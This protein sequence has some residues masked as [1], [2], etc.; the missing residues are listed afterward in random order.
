MSKKHWDPVAAYKYTIG[1]CSSFAF[2]STSDPAAT[3]SS[4][5]V[6]YTWSNSVGTTYEYGFLAYSVFSSSLSSFTASF[7]ALRKLAASVAYRPRVPTVA[8]QHA[9][10]ASSFLASSFTTSSTASSFNARNIA[11]LGANCLNPTLIFSAFVIIIDDDAA[12][13]FFGP[14]T[15]FSIADSINR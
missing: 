9:F 10:L 14:T 8:K 12:P 15:A 7:T 1:D 4:F 2:S 11:N 13:S 3:S 6:G 5:P